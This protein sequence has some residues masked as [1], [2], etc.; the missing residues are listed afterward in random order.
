MGSGSRLRSGRNDGKTSARNSHPV[1]PTFCVAQA[2]TP[3]GEAAFSIPILST[4]KSPFRGGPSAVAPKGA[5]MGE[6]TLPT[7]LPGVNAWATQTNRGWPGQIVCPSRE[8]TG[9]PASRAPRFAP[10]VRPTHP[11]R[12]LC[13]RQPRQ[14]VLGGTRGPP[15]L[16]LCPRNSESRYPLGAIMEGSV[17]DQQFAEE[18]VSWGN[19]SE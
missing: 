7:A 17:A 6:I 1:I 14:Q 11:R 12:L 4:S 5:G 15:K 10:P 19:A 18:A 13:L 3:G 9:R 8:A 2:F 16:V